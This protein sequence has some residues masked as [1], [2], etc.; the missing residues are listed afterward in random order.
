MKMTDLR[1]TLGDQIT[2]L[3]AGKGDPKTANAIVN[4]AGKIIASVRLEMDYAKM[5][6]AAPRIQLLADKKRRP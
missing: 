4:A 6:G 3:R 5:V 1:A 2:K